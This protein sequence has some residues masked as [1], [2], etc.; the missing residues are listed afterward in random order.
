MPEMNIP[1]NLDNIADVAA[2][3]AFFD[4]KLLLMLGVSPRSV[5]QPQIATPTAAECE[6]REGPGKSAYEVD[7][8][9]HGPAEPAPAA[10]PE[11]GERPG[12]RR[13]TKIEIAAERYGVSIE[14]IHAAAGGECAPA[15][16]DEVAARLSVA[17]A[18][19]EGPA[20]T[21]VE[22]EPQSEEQSEP[23]PQ[24]QQEILPPEPAAPTVAEP[25]GFPERT[26]LPEQEILPPEPPAGDRAYTVDDVTAVIQAISDKFSVPHALALL[27]VYGAKSR[28]TLAP[29]HYA[30]FVQRGEAAVASGV[31][32]ADVK[33]EG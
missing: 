29:E 1:V 9:G 27:G 12:R 8:F 33:V 22:P 15:D 28:K 19:V 23:A 26:I 11:Q 18:Y 24:P 31:W 21:V 7:A 30:A 25:A 32:P 5:A 6:V 3:K 16:A 20:E 10:E 2:A 13:R 4:Q 17:A 14:A